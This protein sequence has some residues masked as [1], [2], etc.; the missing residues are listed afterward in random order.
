MKKFYSEVAVA[1]A[2]STCSVALDGRS[3]KTPDQANYCLPT[4]NL[5]NA[6]AAEWRAQGD[7]IDPKSMPLTMIASAAVDRAASKPEDVI[8]SI[9]RFA[10]TD[11]LCYRAERPAQLVEKQN[12]TWQP[13]L[14][15]ASVSLDAKLETTVGIVPIEQDGEAIAALRKKLLTCDHFKLA[16]LHVLSAALGS[17]IL[18]LAVFECHIDVEQA[19]E[20]SQ[21]DEAFQANQWGEDDEAGE[22]RQS[23]RAEATVA[24]Q[25]LTLLQA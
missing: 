16:A 12:E 23:V 15:W 14:D 1:S 20:A 24:A 19:V 13:L 10:A 9:M 4:W 21:L 11:L 18:A 2:G 22:R 8:D 25:F 3:L 6:I 5:A 7:E 17:I